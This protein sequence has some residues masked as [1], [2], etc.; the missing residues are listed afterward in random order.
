MYQWFLARQAFQNDC[1]TAVNSLDNSNQFQLYLHYGPSNGA[2]ENSRFRKL[3]I[4]QA[5]K[6]HM[7]A[8]TLFFEPADDLP[9][10]S[11]SEVSFVSK[12]IQAVNGILNHLIK[13]ITNPVIS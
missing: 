4:D 1:P 10:W 11:L 3:K 12:M 2:F 6:D 7:N 9:C 13:M 5:K 8:K